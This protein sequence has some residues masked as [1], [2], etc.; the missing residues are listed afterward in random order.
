MPDSVKLVVEP[1]EVELTPGG[2]PA[3]VTVRVVNATRIVDEFDIR[4]IGTG[5]WLT[6]PP[7]SVRLFPEAEGTVQLTLSIPKDLMVPAGPR[8]V[9]V[10][11]MSVAN[12]ALTVTER[13]RVVVGEVT[14]EESLTLEP[15]MIHGGTDGAA[16]VRVRNRGNAPLQLAFTGEDP[17]RVVRFVFDP[18]MVQVPPTGEAWARLSISAPRPMSGQEQSRSLTIR[19]EGAHVPLVASGTFVQAPRVT[20][21]TKTATRI[22][23]VLIGGAAMIAGAFLQ[24]TGAATESSHT[25]LELNYVNYVNST[26]G[27]NLGQPF[28][29]LS[30]ETAITLTSFGLVTIVLG[31]ISLLGLLSRKGRPTR[32]AA[33]FAFLVLVALAV[34]LVIRSGAPPIGAGLVISIVGSLLALIGGLLARRE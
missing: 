7:G 8:V 16:V 29:A 28:N 34:T 11:A 12:S 9:G 20:G 6:A 32:L 1:S 10:Q 2:S 27:Q 23:L 3:Q 31:A 30:P 24:W 17:E 5:Q 21:G 14:A 26:F 18:P 25:G 22:A 19:A 4:I 13:I 15:Q 33:G